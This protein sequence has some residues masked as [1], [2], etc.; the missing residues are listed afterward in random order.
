M[1][2]CYSLYSLFAFVHLANTLAQQPYVAMLIVHVL[3]IAMHD[4]I[5][6]MNI[7][8]SFTSLKVVR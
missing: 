3:N 6:T 7:L 4:Y 2:F 1:G 8:V 5:M